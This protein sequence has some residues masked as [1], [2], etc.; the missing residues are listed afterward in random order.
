MVST[1]LISTYSGWTFF[2]HSADQK[3]YQYNSI[4][5][6]CTVQILFI[7]IL[8]QSWR[9]TSD[10]TYT[11]ILNLGTVLNENIGKMHFKTT[12]K[13]P[14]PLL[15]SNCRAPCPVIARISRPSYAPQ[16]AVASFAPCKT[17]KLMNELAEELS[18]LVGQSKQ[19]LSDET[20]FQNVEP[21]VASPCWTLHWHSTKYSIIR[22]RNPGDIETSWTKSSMYQWR[23]LHT[24]GERLET[25]LFF[26]FFS[27]DH[28]TSTDDL[29]RL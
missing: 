6:V 2:G 23:N 29:S 25:E 4:F 13:C 1:K 21:D 19:D 27:R 5:Y 16:P 17:F 22:I 12:K 9:S 14:S 15:P 8:D 3:S 11:Y 26:L 18:K 28:R 20:Y 7:M 24:S 10:E